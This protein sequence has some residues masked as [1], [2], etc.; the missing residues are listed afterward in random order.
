[1][2]LEVQLVTNA[3]QTMVWDAGNQRVGQ[4]LTIS[5]RTVTGISFKM[6]KTG[7]PAGTLTFIIKKV[8][9]GSTVAS[10]LWGNIVD[11]PTSAAWISVTF[12]TP[13]YINQEVRIYAEV[14][15]ATQNASNCAIISINNTDVKAGENITFG[16]GSWSQY[17][18]Q[19]C[20]YMYTYGEG[21]TPPADT[22]FAPTAGILYVHNITS[23][24]ANV[25]AF[26]LDLGIP[27]SVTQYGICWDITADPT[28]T[29]SGSG[30]WG[31]TS[32]GVGAVGPFISDATGLTPGTT[33]YIRAYAVNATGT[34][35]GAQAIITTLAAAPTVYTYEC[36]DVLSTTATGN[37]YIIS[38]GDAAV[39]QYG[40][41]WV[42]EATYAGGAHP[43]TV[44]DVH[45]DN[46]PPGAGTVG[47]F[48]SAI[49]GLTAGLTY[50]CRAYATNSYG[51]TYGTELIAI[52]IL[53]S[54]ANV[55]PTVTTSAC[56][57]IVSTGAKGNG[58]I[59]SLGIPATVTQHGHCWS[60]SPNPT[61]ALTTKTVLGAATATGTFVSVITGLTAGTTY[62][63]RAYAIN[64]AGTAYGKNV[65][66]VPS[67][68]GG[69][70]PTYPTLPTTRV[71]G[72]V[73][74]YDRLRG[75][76]QLE[77]SLGDTTSVLDLP[78]ELS[79]RSATAEKQEEGETGNVV[80]ALTRL[81]LV[82]KEVTEVLRIIERKRQP[83]N[84]ATDRVTAPF[85]MPTRALTPREAGI[86]T[87]EFERLKK[88]PGIK[89]LLE[90]I[91]KQR[92]K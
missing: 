9:D 69:G 37:G 73:H 92:P 71:T 25:H 43:P 13:V 36:S 19:D 11:L 49:T 42:D 46:M 77:I 51:T 86:T 8:S 50:Y 3:T 29:D 14:S 68:G 41:C 24:A 54:A 27:A 56:T 20:A 90:E 57:E 31:K 17:T 35:Y 23:I 38:I 74:R 34:S 65:P 62:Y 15:I 87:E 5:D 16:G 78:Y 33:Y 66:V 32:L 22:S 82:K 4:R 88:M 53:P 21:G 1:M 72:L 26:I 70:V 80:E 64:Q 75:I 81:G 6:F 12:D 47:A 48:A 89:K 60:T 61:T 7:T 85:A 40:H 28:T 45:T 55:A 91:L 10:K 2:A 18:D 84:V 79:G 58:S 52:T 30:S 83:M 44:A 39:T 59:T 67:A 63:V 76:Y